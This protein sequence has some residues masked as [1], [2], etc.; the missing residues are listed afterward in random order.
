[1][2]GNPERVRMQQPGATDRKLESAAL[3]RTSYQQ[4]EQAFL[5]EDYQ[6]SLKQIREALDKVQG[7]H[8]EPM[9]LLPDV[10][11]P[12]VKDGV[13][14]CARNLYQLDRYEEFEVLLATAGRWGL[15]PEGMPELDVVQLSFAYKRGQYQ[16]VVDE[17]TAFIEAT[18]LDL[19]P[20][21]AEFLYLRGLALSS[22]GQPEAARED[23]ETA[24]SLFR[25][26]GDKRECARCANLMGILF[27]RAADFTSADRWFRQA[28]QLHK[29]LGLRK[30][31]GGNLLNLGIG[32]YKRGDFNQALLE[33]DAASVLLQQVDAQVSLCRTAVA[34]GHTLR[35]MRRFSEA[36]ET[37]L[38]A[39][40]RANELL[41]AR[42]EA[43]ALEYLGDVAMDQNQMDK[44]RRYYSRALAV[45]HSLAPDGDVVM[46]VLH[47]QG[48]CLARMGR[49]NEGIVL[50]KRALG[51][52]RNQGDRCEEGQI[53]VALAETVFSLGDLES[54][55]RH[56]ALATD[57]L[58]AVGARFELA[59]ARL[60]AARVGLA[61]LDS[62][63]G[64]D[65]ESALDEGW[66]QTLAAMD[67][68]LRSGI[69]HWTVEA[70]RLL[71][72]ISNQRADEHSAATKAPRKAAGRV[73][74]PSTT[75]VHVSAR[76]RD[77]IQMCDAFADSREPVLITGATGT[78]KELFARR[79][80][81]RSSRSGAEL[82]CVNTT[83]IPESVFA[84]EFFGH[85]R[86]SF[87]GADQDGLGLAAKAHGGTLFLDEIGEMPQSLQPRLLRLLQDGTYHALG[88]PTERQVDLRLVAATNADLE[89]MV[90]RGTFRA[91][92]YYRL[93]ILELKIP[94]MVERREDVLPLLRHFLSLDED[95]QVQPAEFFN[96]HSL[97]LLERYDWPGNV[98]EVA[99]VASQARVQKASCGRV[100][101]E[102][103]SFGSETILL[104][105]PEAK[106]ELLVNE[107]VTGSQDRRSRI[108]LALA[109]TEG[110]RA[111]AARKLGV[112]RSTLYRRMEKLGIV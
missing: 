3:D 73:N 24:H 4:A 58:D 19:P 27:F 31:M 52:A 98:R 106:A 92:L 15:V 63:I 12:R 23:A 5:R 42:E 28:F 7:S 9:A 86:G 77:L 25:V 76:M 38:A 8:L 99:M 45:G 65:R 82:V 68:F 54:A 48:L 88:D 35:L 67:T 103:G 96:A 94:P 40:A 51:L 46:E 18:R 37:L 72:V 29:R 6:S 69:E 66:R 71:N 95:R 59:K 101:I 100:A 85:V 10:H 57:L 79:L 14:L 55:L 62:A 104:S 13:V 78:G 33:F 91:D 74:V 11:A 47:R 97:E 17:T 80:H 30:N 32:C 2:R 20:V 89:Q 112:S 44:A 34:R 61:R 109:E 111:E 83:A 102:L 64:L 93:K 22:L 41:L 26:L 84:R 105:G 108:L 53:R 21:I 43:L 107:P 81:Q 49:E 90:A 36:Q 16:Q 87:S 1:M 75:I 39:F 56:A 50:L 70:R 60:V 110:N